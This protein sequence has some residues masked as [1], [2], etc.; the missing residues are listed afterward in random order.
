MADKWFDK[1]FLPSIFAQAGHKAM[2]L[3]QKQ[4]AVC[5][6]RMERT[7]VTYRVE[8]GVRY[9]HYNFTYQWGERYVF[10]SYSKKNGCG[11]IEF[12]LDAGEERQ[13]QAK[14]TE[15]LQSYI[16][17][18]ARRTIKKHG[19]DALDKKISKT[20]INGARR[21][22]EFLNDWS[23]NECEDLSAAILEEIRKSSEQVRIYL[24]ARK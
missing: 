3:T 17:D 4:T 9:S 1:V 8:S 23:E 14:E 22:A 16:R 19:I 2:Y 21:V 11:W 13:A 7:I 15:R 6:Q 10:M 18:S 12:G 24:E 20:S 5:V